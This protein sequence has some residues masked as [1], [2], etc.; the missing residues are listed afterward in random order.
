MVLGLRAIPFKY[1][2]EGEGKSKNIIK[3]TQHYTLP[4]KKR[5]FNFQIFHDDPGP[6]QWPRVMCTK[7]NVKDS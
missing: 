1:I 4:Q 3:T 2:G 7:G 5:N 6:G